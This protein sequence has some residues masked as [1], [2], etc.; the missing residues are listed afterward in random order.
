MLNPHG[1]LNPPNPSVP[2]PVPAENPYPS[3]RYGFLAGM[4]KGSP[5]KPQSYP[6]QSL[7]VAEQQRKEAKGHAVASFKKALAAWEKKRDSAKAKGK[8]FVERKPKQDA[9]PK[10]IPKLKLKDFLEHQGKDKE[11]EETGDHSSEDGGDVSDQ[12]V[13]AATSE[14]DN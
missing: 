14:D 5:G 4:G 8:K 12:T 1:L 9:A 7:A 2:V 6:C 3:R 11:A 10:A 13:S